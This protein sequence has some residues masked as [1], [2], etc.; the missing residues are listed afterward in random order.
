MASNGTYGVVYCGTDGLG[1]GVFNLKDGIVVGADYVG[2]RYRGTATETANGKITFDLTF[3]VPADVV[4]VQGTAAQELPHSRRITQ[5]LPAEFGDGTPV[6]FE[7]GLGIVTAMIKRI[8]DGLES[9]AFYGFT[10]VA[11]KPPGEWRARNARI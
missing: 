6:E 9:A 2:G 11:N 4:L 8:P 5:T 1:V 10:L 3:K 7:T